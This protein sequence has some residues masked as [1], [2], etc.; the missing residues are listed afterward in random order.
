MPF[1]LGIHPSEIDAA[2]QRGKIPAE[3]LVTMMMA[4]SILPEWIL[5]GQGPCCTFDVWDSHMRPGG[6]DA[7]ARQADRAALRRLPS[8]ALAKE[9]VRRIAVAQTNGFVRWQEMDI[10]LG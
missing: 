4:E 8:V 2:R 7:T 9:L 5:T 1:F 6:D 3:W 10:G